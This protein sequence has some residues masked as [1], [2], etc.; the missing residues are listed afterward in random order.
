MEESIQPIGVPNKKLLGI[1][2]RQFFICGNFELISKD[3]YRPITVV[4]ELFH[5]SFDLAWL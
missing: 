5:E 4:A 2:I 3:D 1:I